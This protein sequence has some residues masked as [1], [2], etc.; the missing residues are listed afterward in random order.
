MADDAK[1]HDPTTRR[2]QQAREAGR[3]AH[4]HELASAMLLLGSLAVLL[5]AGAALVEFLADFLKSGLSGGAWQTC[6]GGSDAPRRSIVAQWNALL[7]ALARL[8]L[9]VLSGATL[10][11]VA[12]HLVQ[13]GFLFRPRGIVPDLAR[14]SPLAGFQRIFSG[15]SAARL[16]SGVVKIALVGG[17]AFWGLWSRREELT[18][19]AS[20]DPARLAAQA[21]NLCFWTVAQVGGALLA[22][23]VVDYALQRWR[24][25]RDLRMTPQEVRDEARELEG[26][27]KQ[28][29]RRRELA[30][31]HSAPRGA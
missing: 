20:L 21:W 30:H 4:S 27:A 24:L 7:P 10:V 19:L 31:R 8:L 25:E 11:A 16:A 14:T 3:V 15:A 28:H 5:V 18:S 26:D 2:R 22:L 6:I 17:I 9:P 23:A 1:S 12:A 13:T 29:A